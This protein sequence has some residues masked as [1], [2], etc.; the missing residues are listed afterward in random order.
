MLSRA[1]AR[2]IWVRK[3]K[4]FLRHVG[5]LEEKRDTPPGAARADDRRMLPSAVRLTPVGG[6]TPEQMLPQRVQL[7]RSLFPHQRLILRFAPG[8]KRR[9]QGDRNEHQCER[10]LP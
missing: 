2:K 1:S 5:G 7:F 8:R 6:S 4:T 10:E 9:H 3:L